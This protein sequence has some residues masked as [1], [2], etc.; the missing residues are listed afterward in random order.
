MPTAMN[1]TRHRLD[2]PGSKLGWFRCQTH[3]PDLEVDGGFFAP[4][5]LDL[6]LDGLSLV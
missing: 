3:S 5:A 1:S 6:E 2:I 4:I